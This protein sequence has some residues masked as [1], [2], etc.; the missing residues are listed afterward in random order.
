MGAP[1]PVLWALAVYFGALAVPPALR[2]VRGHPA[3]ALRCQVNPGD[4]AADLLMA[5]GMLAMVSPVGAPVPPAGWL[6]VFALAAAWSAAEWVR[7][8]LR[9]TETAPCVAPQCGHHAVMACAMLVMFAAMATHA[10]ADPWPALAQH[11]SGT[12]PALLVIPA[13][14]Y[15]F[16]D[17][18]RCG[19][20]IAR[21]ATTRALPLVF[22]SRTR[23]TARAGMSA[24]MGAMLLAM[25]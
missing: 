7:V 25:S 24:A 4:E 23:W 18:A 16:V 19:A 3:A 20:R 14:T 6:A 9:R 8:R 12:T 17:I 11:A 2:L 21:P 13:A 10:G 22:Q 1:E 15:C 5:L